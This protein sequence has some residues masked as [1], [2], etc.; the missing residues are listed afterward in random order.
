VFELAA[1]LIR[2]SRFNAL[3]TAQGVHLRV[4]FHTEST[5]FFTRINIIA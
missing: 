3:D 4:S 5:Y 2:L 1:L